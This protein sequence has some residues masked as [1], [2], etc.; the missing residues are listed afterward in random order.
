MLTPADMA[1]E[2]FEGEWRVPTSDGPEPWAAVDKW[3]KRMHECAIR[4]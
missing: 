2:Y 3:I 4:W 1:T